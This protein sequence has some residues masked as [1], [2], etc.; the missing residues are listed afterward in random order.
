VCQDI[1]DSPAVDRGFGCDRVGAKFACADVLDAGG[2]PVGL[3]DEGAVL[4][5][6]L[7]GRGVVEDIGSLAGVSTADEKLG[8]AR[9]DRAVAAHGRGAQCLGD[10]HLLVECAAGWSW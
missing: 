9:P 3:G 7:Q 8:V 6:E 5:E 10:G 4:V 2:G 1:G